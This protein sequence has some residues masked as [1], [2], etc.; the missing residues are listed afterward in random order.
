[1][2]AAASSTGRKLFIEGIQINYNAPEKPRKTPTMDSWQLISYQ[3]MKPKLA[4]RQRFQ[5]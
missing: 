2:H 3:K 5:P 4:K 1:M